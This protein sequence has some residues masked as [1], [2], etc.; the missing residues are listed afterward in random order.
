[1]YSRNCHVSYGTYD[2]F[3]TIALH[4]IVLKTPQ[5]FLCLLN[6]HIPPA[7]CEGDPPVCSGGRAPWQFVLAMRHN[8]MAAGQCVQ[9]LKENL[10]CTME[11]RGNDGHLRHGASTI[12]STLLVGAISG[13]KHSVREFERGVSHS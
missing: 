12:K 13:C 4:R 10:A 2:L 5:L 7:C 11:I 3:G 9:Q 1:M 6:Q 8:R